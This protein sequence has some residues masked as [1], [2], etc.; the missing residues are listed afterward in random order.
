MIRLSRRGL[1][2]GAGA[3][4]L[5]ATMRPARDRKSVV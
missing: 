2:A 1:M 3:L 4:G 5:S